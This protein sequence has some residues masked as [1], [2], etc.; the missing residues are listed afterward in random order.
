MQVG[1]NLSTSKLK[2]K[3]ISSDEEARPTSKRK[4]DFADV[5]NISSPIKLDGPALYAQDDIS[6][7]GLDNILNGDVA[8]DLGDLHALNV[9]DYE[10]S[11]DVDLQVSFPCIA[12]NVP[13]STDIDSLLSSAL[14]GVEDAPVSRKEVS[15][16]IAMASVGVPFVT[17]VIMKAVDASF[18]HALEGLN[19]STIIDPQRHA[20]LEAVYSLLP[21]SDDIARVAAIRAGLKR[22]ISIS[23]DMQQSHKEIRSHSHEK[24]EA[25]TVADKEC[26]LLEEFLKGTDDKLASMEEQYAEER[27]HGETL[28]AQLEK[29]N[30]RMHQIEEGVE[31]LKLTRSSKQAE[32]KELRASLSEVNA[33]ANQAL[34]DLK[35]KIS[36][37]DNEVESILEQMKNLHA[38]P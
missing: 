4:L 2:D 6:F 20:L 22:L 19:S 30:T 37:M 11:I 10:S 38:V 21:A 25:F 23:N 34:E 29:V 15:S 35:Q 26:M 9:D 32:A 12:S 13:P 18:R 17:E 28:K 5:E 1:E 33:K 24:E 16:H 36:T 3:A 7:T 27:K 8:H 14:N 31:Q